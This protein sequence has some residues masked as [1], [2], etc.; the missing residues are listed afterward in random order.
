ME[1]E[2]PAFM[3]RCLLSQSAVLSWGAFDCHANDGLNCG[4]YWPSQ[5]DQLGFLMFGRSNWPDDLGPQDLVLQLQVLN[6]LAQLEARPS[7]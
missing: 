3:R 7:G 1:S 4:I 5:L 2:T 6:L